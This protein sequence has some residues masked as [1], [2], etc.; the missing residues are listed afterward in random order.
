MG[1]LSCQAL[2]LGRCADVEESTTLLRVS[3]RKPDEFVES[4][5]ALTRCIR[6]V[7]AQS[8]ASFEV[9]STQA[10][11]LRYIGEHSPISQA[12]LARG[13]ITD[14][15]LT[16]RALESLVERGWIRRKRSEEDRRQYVLELSAAGQRV[17]KRVD[18]ARE[19]IAQRIAKVLDEKDMEDFARI[20]KKLIAGFGDG[21]GGS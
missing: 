20:A 16:G 11:F 12:D 21:S 8:Y 17:R 2:G 1:P 19:E 10:K 5:R 4:F 3:R 6:S 7:A 14:P 9:G 15:A 13:T 18:E